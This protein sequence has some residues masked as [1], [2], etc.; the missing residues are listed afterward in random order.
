MQIA[1]RPL[2]DILPLKTLEKIKDLTLILMCKEDDPQWPDTWDQL[3]SITR[4][5]LG[6]RPE[7]KSG[8]SLLLPSRIE[9]LIDLQVTVQYSS[10]H[11]FGD[12]V[13][14]SLIGD[15]PV[16]SRLQVNIEGIKS[17]TGSSDRERQFRETDR[18]DA[19]CMAL[20]S[21]RQG[22]EY[23]LTEVK[24]AWPSTEHVQLIFTM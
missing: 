15:L 16:L 18:L 11:T 6:I 20:Q 4:H 8:M 12:I 14:N 17:I 23:I 7:A 5:K 9:S 24:G 10:F 13:L 2:S 21:R 19:I 22:L 3:T 1:E